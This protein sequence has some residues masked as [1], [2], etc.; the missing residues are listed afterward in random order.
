MLEPGTGHVSNRSE[1]AG[2]FCKRIKNL[3]A[4]KCKEVLLSVASARDQNFAVRQQ[5]HLMTATPLVHVARRCEQAC[6]R[7]INFGC[8]TGDLGVESTA[9]EHP[10]IR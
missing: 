6:S 1:C 8:I 7:I 4:G 5:G 10:A 9:H 2:P 3:C